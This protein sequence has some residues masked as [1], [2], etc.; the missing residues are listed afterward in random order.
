[1]YL[2]LKFEYRVFLKKVFHEREE[3]MQEEM[4]MTKQKEN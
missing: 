2:N 3:K 1:M 4:K